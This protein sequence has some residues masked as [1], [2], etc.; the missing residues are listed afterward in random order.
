M[1]Y[2]WG[3]NETKWCGRVLRNFRR[4]KTILISIL[5]E[6]SSVICPQDPQ[7]VLNC[8][9]EFST[10]AASVELQEMTALFSET[11]VGIWFDH[12]QKILPML[13][14]EGQIEYF[15]KRGMS[16]LG[17]M[18]VRR[19]TITIG[20][21]ISTGLEYYYYDVVIDKYS[22]QD[23]IQVMA[24]ITAVLHRVRQDFQSVQ[25]VMLGSDNASCFASH[26]A[27]PYIHNLNKNV[28]QAQNLRVT[29]WVYTEACTGKNRLDTH[30]SFVNILLRSYVMDGNN[31][32]TEADIYQG[33]CHNG[34]IKGSTTILFDGASLLGPLLEKDGKKQDFKCTRTG[35]RETHEI[36]F[37]DPRLGDEHTPKIYT[38]SDITIP[39]IITKQKLKNYQPNNLLTVLTA[40]SK[41]NKK[42]FFLKDETTPKRA[43]KKMQSLRMH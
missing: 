19:T 24:V 32:V 11:R 12:K 13:C 8:L 22:S 31:V 36:V 30:F 20:D 29:N 18:L 2:N 27:I 17:A 21:A 40:S 14:R 34:G 33:L 23:N 26:D 43:T 35:V 10:T 6:V 16:L 25:E 5:K 38:I 7:T 42:A 9:A 28:M 4:A 3:C 1:R 37:P 39:E 41:S 15:G